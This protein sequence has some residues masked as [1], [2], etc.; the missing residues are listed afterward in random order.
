[1]NRTNLV[2]SGL[3]ALTLG[4][5]FGTYHTT[6]N[7]HAATIVGAVGITVTLGYSLFSSFKG[8]RRALP[9]EGDVVNA[10]AILQARDNSP[11]DEEI[12]KAEFIIKSVTM[13]TEDDIIVA[14]TTLDNAAAATSSEVAAAEQVF[15]DAAKRE[16]ADEL[17]NKHQQSPTDDQVA[18]ANAALARNLAR[19]PNPWPRLI[20]VV[21]SF[22]LAFP[23]PGLLAEVKDRGWFSSASSSNEIAESIPVLPAKI[24]APISCP[25]A[26]ALR[27]EVKPSGDYGIDPQFKSGFFFLPGRDDAF[28]I[29]SASNDC[30]YQFTP[31]KTPGPVQV[32]L[33]R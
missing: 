27:F 24:H 17:L 11:S 18:A 8:W 3:T 5:V 14:R 1:M 29:G 20:A 21:A 28:R 25:E 6:N 22:V 7:L 12:R 2:L 31:S 13:P 10:R 32:Q 15:D 30:V 19:G 9:K 26:S 23:L 16:A 33:V 4:G